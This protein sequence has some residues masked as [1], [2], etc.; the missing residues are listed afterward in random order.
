MFSVGDAMLL[1]PMPFR[2][3]R[4]LLQA[5][6]LGDDGRL[7]SYGWLDY[8]DVASARRAVGEFAAYQQ[9]DGL[10]RRWVSLAFVKGRVLDSDS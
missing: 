10:L 4:S 9:R 2:E 7:L 3:P 1:R 5:G 6:S 8:Q